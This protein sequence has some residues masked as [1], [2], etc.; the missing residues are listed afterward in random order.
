MNDLEKIYDQ[1]AGQ[2]IVNLENP[3]E[4]E[5]ESPKLAAGILRRWYIALLIFIVVC[6]LGLPAIWFLIKPVYVVTGQIHIAPIVVD[7]LTDT[8]D[9]GDISDYQSFINTQA[10]MVTS[11]RVVQ[12][13]ADNLK[14]R[15]LA[16]FNNEQADYITKIKQRFMGKKTPDPAEFVKQAL[17]SQTVTVKAPR[18]RELI[19][20]SMYSDNYNDA[21]QV[22]NAFIN[23][24]MD[25]GVDSSTQDADQKLTALENERKVKAEEMEKLRTQIYQLAQ[26]YGTATL[27]GRQDMMLRNVSSLNA[28]LTDLEASK[29]NIK[30][31]IQLLE[32]V[33]EE[34]LSPDELLKM[35][36]QYINRDTSVV[37]ITERIAKL[38]QSLIVARETLTPTNSEVIVQTKLLKTMKEH[39]VQRK[40]EASKEFDELL[41]EEVAKAGE[42]K[43]LN[44]RNL[45][46]QTEVY[47]KILRDTIEKADSETI[48]LGRIQLNIQDL[49]DKLTMTKERY[50]TVLKRIQDL[51][52][53]R[54]RQPRIS[55][56]D[57]A[58]IASIRDRRTKLSFGIILA[59]LACGMWLAYI[60][61][62]ADQRL[63]TPEDVAKRIGIRI[64]G[65]T[66]SM[67][68]VKRSLLPE[69]II[70]DYQTIRANIGL[71]GDEGIPKK[72]VITSPGMKEGKTTFAI[73]LATSLADAGKKVLLIDGDLRKPDVAR[74]LNLPKDSR[75]LQDVLSGIKLERA[76]QS[77]ASNGLDV[78][79]ADFR[80]A[81]DAYELLALSSTTERI[82][83]ISKQY[84]HIIIDT[85]PVLAFPDAMMWAKVGNAVILT[86]FAGHTT[87]PELR[88]AKERLMQINVRVLGTVI[89]S[90]GSEHSYYR[91][92]NSYYAKSAKTR[93]MKRKTLLQKT[94]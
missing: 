42:A 8:R 82:N 76:V 63:R 62:K 59:G 38:E 78:L 94:D 44:A 68:T 9:R 17:L 85:P 92:D 64:I 16:F 31:Q 7:I 5:A 65:T 19:E 71:L 91:Q 58:H 54:K 27:S 36:Q 56:H 6:A 14:G 45:L 39:L 90:V 77:L 3:P 34:H 2:E 81:A 23:A 74:L 40:E 15:N 50:D 72:L 93:R 61:D 80:D 53:Q 28:R 21:M 70:E 46:E 84:D 48:R 22:V 29:M 55:V 60:R 13:V 51:Q 66:T 4:S 24:Y 69:H 75:G 1:T 11:S 67:D 83:E 33:K 20:I 86:S 87:L 79:A 10:E 35:R 73:N 25:V 52:M 26:E 57:Y 32:R 89:S 88:E 43:L 18:G 41:S 37:S 12:R 30:A 47:E 49:Q